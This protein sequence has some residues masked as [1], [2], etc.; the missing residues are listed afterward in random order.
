M[1]HK[2]LNLKITHLCFLILTLL[3]TFSSANAKQSEFEKYSAIVV[4]C[5]TGEVLYE[6]NAL[7]PRYPASLTKI[8][9]LYMVFEALDNG[10]LSL[11]RPLH[12]SA[13][14]AN[15]KPSRLGLKPGQTILVRDAILA[16]VTKSANDVATVIAENLAGSEAEFC[17]QMTL[18]AH[19][20]GMYSTSFH[21]ASGLPNPLQ[22]TTAQDIAKLS[23]AV[24]RHYPHYYHYF[25][26]RNFFY[27]GRSYSNHNH[28]L[29][30][31]D[32]LDGIKTGFIN[33]SGY[34][35]AAS[36]VRGGKRLIAVVMGGRTANSRDRQVE[37]LLDESFRKIYQ[38]N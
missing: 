37:M 14:A 26:T 20:L 34:N 29:K 35:L 38:I 10:S 18:R 36:A 33:A 28:L 4:D 12:V 32:G 9:T 25:R 2:S 15:Q 22:R 24:L 5:R 31:Y 3:L 6:K 19:S 7:A 21:N 16:L 23:L 30:R 17:R 8:M 13:Y 1:H 27:K 11:D